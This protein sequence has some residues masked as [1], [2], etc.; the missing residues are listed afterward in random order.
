MNFLPFGSH[1]I[2]SCSKWVESVTGTEAD[3]GEQCSG[4][5]YQGDY[6]DYRITCAHYMINE[7]YGMLYLSCYIYSCNYST[8]QEIYRALSQLRSFVA[9]IS[10]PRPE[11]SI[12]GRRP[13]GICS[14][15]VMEHLFLWIKCFIF[16]RLKLALY[17]L[18]IDRP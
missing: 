18:A 6:S 15:L 16:I 3:L 17:I 2:L 7:Q 9:E 11:G 13:F 4:V 5:W 10:P 14:E 8:G 1:E 12:R